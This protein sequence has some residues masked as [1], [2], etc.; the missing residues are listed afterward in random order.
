MKVSFAKYHALGNDFLIIEGGRMPAK[1]ATAKFAKSICDRRTGVGAD[2]ILYLSPSRRADIR[3]DVFNA[4]GGWAEKSGNGLRI[5]AAYLARKKPRKTYQIEMGGS[6]NKVDL[7]RK[8]PNGFMARAEIGK[9]DFRTSAVPMKSKLR[10]HINRELK[11]G[12]E[13]FLATCLSVG[14][15]HCVVLVEKFDFDWQILGRQIEIAKAFPKATNVEFVQIVNRGKIRVAE[16]ER[17]AG[18]TGSSGTGAAAAVA[19]MV[20]QGLVDRTCEVVFEP[21]SLHVEWR[22]DGD[23]IVLTGPVEFV[24][25]GEFEY[26]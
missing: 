16:W 3:V 18:A 5:V 24:A 12:Q 19:S 6:V 20:I 9:P 8:T 22:A 1:R 13:R 2:G 4:D 21:G 10:Y 17:G 15:P 25:T 7:V 11:I 26:R 14:N 23:A